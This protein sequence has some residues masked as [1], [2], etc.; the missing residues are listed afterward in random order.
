MQAFEE[1][2]AN[3]QCEIKQLEDRVLSEREASQASRASIE[4]SVHKLGLALRDKDQELS[5]VKTRNESS[6]CDL[7]QSR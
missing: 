3:L 6:A 5:K 4:A 1:Q 7:A 2:E